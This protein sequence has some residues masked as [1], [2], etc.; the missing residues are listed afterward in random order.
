M[1]NII[2]DLPYK[3]GG[4]G[5]T[6]N[7]IITVIEILRKI[8]GKQSKEAG[9]T[10]S[11]NDNSSL[12][13]I[14]RITQIFSDF[15]EQVHSKSLELEC[16]IGEE[17]DFYVEELHDI[18]QENLNKVNMYGIRIKR[19]ERQIDKIALN[20]KGIIDK[21]ISKRISLDNSQCKEIVKM[22]PGSKKEEAMSL[23]L[24][25]SVK[26]ALA[27]GCEEMRLILEEIYED[28]EIEVI[29]AVES[30]QKQN[31]L[32]KESINLIDKDNYEE[33]AKKQITNAYYLVDAC[34]LIEQIL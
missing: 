13:N 21:E 12:E 24:N 29:G 18:L 33:T 3:T 27:V 20:I 14:D 9:E 25:E 23:F 8:F 10:D 17:I 19:I 5:N 4:D 28:V 11:V 2:K 26:N 1:N 31:E 15:K 7:K 22:I 34:N 6:I 32:F 16:V 30:I